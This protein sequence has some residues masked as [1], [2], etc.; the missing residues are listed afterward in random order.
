VDRQVARLRIVLEK[1]QQ[2]EAV[3][4]G[5]SEIERDRVRLK[6]AR[7]CERPRPGGGHD[8][9]EANVPSKVE[10]DRREGR[11]V[12]HDQHEG[13]VAQIV[14][15][16]ADFEAGGESRWD[17][18]AAIVV[19][20]RRTRACDRGRRRRVQGHE[21]GEG[22]AFAGDRA[23][24]QFAAEQARDLAADGKAKAGAAI[25]TAGGAVGLLE[26]LEDQLLLVLGN[27]DAGVGDRNLDRLVPTLSTGW[28]LLQPP[29]APRT[30]SVTLPLAVNLKALERRLS[31]T[32]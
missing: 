7:H 22:G 16:V 26:R 12:L 32:C 27:A 18:C 3:D 25:F 29:V 9:L 13:I 2:H 23:H 19:A 20:G 30:A 6:L 24:L 14:P 5:E 10:Q 28:F 31:T 17:H 4:V 11:V 8:A 1:V 15:V 21:Q